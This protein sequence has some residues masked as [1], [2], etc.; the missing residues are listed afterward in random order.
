MNN[1]TTKMNN[2]AIKILVTYYDK[3]IT[4]EVTKEAVTASDFVEYLYCIG[5]AIGYD[6]EGLLRAMGEHSELWGDYSFKKEQR[7]IQEEED[8]VN[9]Y[10]EEDDD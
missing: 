8:Q 4:Y 3:T 7:E 9:T 2:E 1:E 10:Y 6:S 5:V